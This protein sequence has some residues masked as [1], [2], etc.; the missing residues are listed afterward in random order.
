VAKKKK[1]FH[2]GTIKQTDTMKK[3]RHSWKIK[4]I[5]KVKDSKKKYNRKNW[6]KEFESET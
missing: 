6:K 3:I 4:P 1:V 5:T 2:L